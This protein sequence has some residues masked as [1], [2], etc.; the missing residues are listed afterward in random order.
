[1]SAKLGLSALQSSRLTTIRFQNRLHRKRCLWG[2]RYECLEYSDNRLSEHGIPFEPSD[3]TL[4]V[5]DGLLKSFSVSQVYNIIG[6][7]V[8]DATASLS[9]TP[10]PRG[11]GADY[12][13]VSMQ[14]YGDQAAA[15]GWELSKYRRSWDLL[16]SMVAEVLY[17][18]VL[19]IDGFNEV[20]S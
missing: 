19:Q 11:R 3:R 15:A 6:R 2:S 9:R 17:N 10:A 4:S 16:V 13:V 5:I 8:R 12:A 1:M 14:K 20:P 7:K 18:A